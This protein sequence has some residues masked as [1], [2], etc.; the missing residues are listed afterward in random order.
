MPVLPGSELV[1]YRV[2]SVLLSRVSR[3]PVGSARFPGPLGELVYCLPW[4]A[5]GVTGRASYVPHL[6]MPRELPGLPELTSQL[7]DP[8]G[9]G[10]HPLG[11]APREPRGIKIAHPLADIELSLQSALGARI[12]SM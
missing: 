1:R 2:S 12:L 10:R 4:V 5:F 11:R 7:A 8:R 9:L 6:A 3:S